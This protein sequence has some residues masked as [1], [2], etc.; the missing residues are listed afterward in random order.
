R[1]SEKVLIVNIVYPLILRKVHC[2]STNHAI[3]LQIGHAGQRIVVRKHP[4]AELNIIKHAF[5]CFMTFRRNIEGF[6]ERKLAMCAVHRQEG[7][8]LEPT[9][10][11]FTPLLPIGS[12]GLMKT[13]LNEKSSGIHG[14]VWYA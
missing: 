2:Q 1:R 12:I 4:V 3:I 14:P 7:T 13:F 9:G 6:T 5:V 8:V 10:I 11:H